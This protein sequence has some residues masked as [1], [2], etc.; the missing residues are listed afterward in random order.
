M[1][2]IFVYILATVFTFAFLGLSFAKDLKDVLE[3]DLSNS[4]KLSKNV[5]GSYF[6]PD[7]RGAFVISTGH[8]LG[9]KVF[10]TGSMTT[11]IWEKSFNPGDNVSSKLIAEPSSYSDNE[12]ADIFNGFVEK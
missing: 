3:N 5:V 1:R 8:S 4:A 7:A 10:A 6:A 11:S 9:S 2:K 12:T